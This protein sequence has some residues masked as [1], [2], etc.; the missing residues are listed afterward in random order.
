MMGKS[1]MDV[2]K[3]REVISYNPESGVFVWRVSSSN[4]RPAGSVAGCVFSTTGYR[5]IRIENK[6][7]PAARLAWAIMTG[8][9][10]LGVVDH[11]NGERADDR[12][13]NLRIA[14]ISQ[15]AANAKKHKD[16]FSGFKGVEFH[17]QTAKWRARICIHGRKISL[18]LFNNKE[19][20]HEA[21]WLAAKNVFAEY[22]RK[23]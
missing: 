17:K 8:E 2:E 5:L 6:I 15:N 23:E 18:G 9:F 21:Y 4:R 19:E 14:S 10:P 20:A 7:F 12:W 3:L 16:N 13:C 22:A 1:V 11:I